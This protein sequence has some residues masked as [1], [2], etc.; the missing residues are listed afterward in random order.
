MELLESVNSARVFV[1]QQ[2]MLDI[3]DC[4]RI[5]SVLAAYQMP[6]NQ[7][8]AIAHFVKTST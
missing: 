8:E 5:V 2:Y 7:V 1:L 4:G 6:S 3:H